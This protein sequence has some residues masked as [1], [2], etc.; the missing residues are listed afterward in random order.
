MVINP[1]SI[2]ICIPEPPLRHDAGRKSP[3]RHQP[4]LHLL[5]LLLPLRHVDVAVLVHVVVVVVELRVLDQR[6]V[7]PAQLLLRVVVDKVIWRLEMT[8]PISI[9]TDKHFVKFYFLNLALQSA[10]VSK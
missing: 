5:F 9:W 10:L 6:Q 7:R 2:I 4:P 1:T 3:R 8:H